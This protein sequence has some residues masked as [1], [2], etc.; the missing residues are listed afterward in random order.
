MRAATERQAEALLQAPPS[1]L[2]VP[3]AAGA[4]TG[5]ASERGEV[6]Q[7]P[8]PWESVSGGGGELLLRPRGCCASAWQRSWCVSGGFLHPPG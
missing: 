5:L 3:Q 1:L 6:R 4:E 8:K 7:V 2:G